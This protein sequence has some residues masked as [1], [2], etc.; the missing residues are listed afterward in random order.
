[1]R[2]DLYRTA[3]IIP[4]SFLADHA[5]ID[6]SACD[7]ILT[8]QRAVRE[9]LIM[10]EVQ[11]RLRAVIGHVNFAVLKRIHSP[12]IDVQIRIQFL[13][14]DLEALRFKDLCDRRGCDALA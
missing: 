8:A 5:V 3:K 2:H 11:I 14:S 13:E 4:A 9:S 12:R 1:M 7:I 10:P 6:L